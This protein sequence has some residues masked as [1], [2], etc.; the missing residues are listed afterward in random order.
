MTQSSSS[1]RSKGNS[2]A[3]NTVAYPSN[4]IA[5]LI[6]FA[7]PFALLASAAFG[8]TTA[9]ESNDSSIATT[10]FATEEQRA[11]VN[12]LIKD[13]GASKYQVRK[14]ATIRLKSMGRLAFDAATAQLRHENPE[15]RIRCRKVA[16]HI[17]TQI[18]EQRVQSFLVGP[19]TSPTTDVPGWDHLSSIVGDTTHSRRW[20]AHMLRENWDIVEQLSTR[21]SPLS[22]VGEVDR[23]NGRRNQGMAPT[24]AEISTVMLFADELP[25]EKLSNTF[26]MLNQFSIKTND[27]NPWEND[28]FR[29]LAGK[30]V[31]E[32]DSPKV[33]YQAFS[34][35][36]R[37]KL[38][39][40]VAPAL[41]TL[42]NESVVGHIKQYALLT[43][44]RFGTAEHI[45]SLAPLYGDQTVCFTRNRPIKL[46]NRVQPP[47][48]ARLAKTTKFEGQVRDAAIA[49]ALHLQS[50][51]P[52]N[53]GFASL[54][55]S[56]QSV[57]QGHS[58]GFSNEENREAVISKVFTS[59]GAVPMWI[60]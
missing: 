29:R 23:L 4:L 17:Q 10:K 11:E 36:L 32:C 60:R 37:R 38:P 39:E 40:G 57:F 43:V 58:L 6:P 12:Q 31:R 26:S 2:P 22:V 16:D 9:S 41:A 34:L 24:A 47:L 8:Q 52:A 33:S 46:V 27:I 20:M 35:A 14:R 51:D 7:M 19:T 54:L 3:P 44:A 42:K 53:F 18:R 49:T 13:L 55:R 56:E 45:E 25:E 5:W 59:A 48:G 1:T 21:N 28:A 30:T 15:V 50:K